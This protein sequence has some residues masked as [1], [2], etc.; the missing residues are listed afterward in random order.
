MKHSITFIL[1]VVA[2][3]LNVS[4]VD[5]Q[6][7]KAGDLLDSQFLPVD[8][9]FILSVQVV[10]QLVEL[11][12]DIAPGHYLY[13]SKLDFE[14]DSVAQ[15]PEITPGESRID[16]YFGKVEVYV[17]ELVV[18]LAIPEDDNEKM[19]LRITYQGCADAGLCYTP[20]KRAFIL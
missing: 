18:N 12:W 14:L 13:R 7:K 6:L 4:T 5:G 19:E 10:D 11:R 15:S 3:L 20:Q 2:V 17:G 1:I 8:E 9:A 16:E